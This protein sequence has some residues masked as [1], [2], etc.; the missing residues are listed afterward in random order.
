M[1]FNLSK[2]AFYCKALRPTLADLL[3]FQHLSWVTTSWA[4]VSQP[5][6]FS[7]SQHRPGSSCHSEP[8]PWPPPIP[9]HSDLLILLF[10]RALMLA[11]HLLFLA[12]PV[13]VTNSTEPTVRMI[14]NRPNTERKP[15][16]NRLKRFVCTRLLFAYFFR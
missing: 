11:T 5:T 3:H 8:L 10:R 12:M 6:Q 9:V 1:P 14:E 2:T 13:C 4:P 16:R 15:K 7:R